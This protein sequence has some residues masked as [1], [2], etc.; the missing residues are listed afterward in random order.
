MRVSDHA[1]LRY[2]EREHGLDVSAVRQ[3]L[4]D[5]ARPAAEIGAIAVQV[6]KVRL[7]FQHSPRQVTVVTVLPRGPL[8]PNRRRTK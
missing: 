5:T 4:A 7:L 1:V 3:H 6:E 8:L 2:L